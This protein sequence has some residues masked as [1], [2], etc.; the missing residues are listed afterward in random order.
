LITH[1]ATTARRLGFE[2]RWRTA[3]PHFVALVEMT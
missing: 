3:F 1:F 2:Q